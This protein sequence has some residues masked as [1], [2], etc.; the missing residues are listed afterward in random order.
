MTQNTQI[1]HLAFSE[2]GLAPVLL[3]AVGRCKFST[4]TPIQEKTIPIATKGEDIIGIAQTGTGKTLAFGLPM[5][6]QLAIKKGMGLVILPTRELAIQVDETLNKI[7]ASMGLRTAIIVGG[8]AMGNQISMIRK[9]PHVIIATP[10]RL[11]D[12]LEHK[13]INLSTVS[14]LV[15]DE[16]DRMLDMGFEPQIRKILAVVPKERQ[17][18]LFSVTMPDKIRSMARHYM[19]T[20][21][22]IEVAAAGTM[23]ENITQE[24]YFVTKDEKLNLLHKLLS[25]HPGKALVFSRTK[26]GAKKLAIKLKNMGYTAADIHSNKSLSQRK[27]ALDGF[28]KNQF[29][30]L[31]ATDIAARG[32][33]VHDIVL[34]VNYDLPDNPEDYVHR[35]GRTGRAGKSSKAVSFAEHSQKYDVKEIERLT[36]KKLPIISLIS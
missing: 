3:D 27:A 31:V 21:V 11:N 20:P 23:A 5:I 32:I 24:L 16:A 8:A 9:N 25:S 29:R 14:V 15:L 34:V 28:K 4:P 30:I 18:M 13:T 22:S 6:Q 7:G 10:G 26:H 12:H 33:D 19:K 2:L 1:R 36:K 17:T 35:I